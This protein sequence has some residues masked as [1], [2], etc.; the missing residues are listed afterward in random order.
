MKNEGKILLIPDLEGKPIKPAEMAKRI[1][2]DPKTKQ[3]YTYYMRS[4][5]R[6]FKQYR[7]KP[8]LFRDDPFMIETKLAEFRTL[9]DFFTKDD[10]LSLYIIIFDIH[11]VS[12]ETREARHK[13]MVKANS[14]NQFESE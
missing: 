4:W 5:C 6:Y 12:E 9:R 2:D 10:W 3:Q 14:L 13:I 8:E 11:S 7:Y 1:S